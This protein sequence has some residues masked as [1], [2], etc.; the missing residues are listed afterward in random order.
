VKVRERFTAASASRQNGALV[1]D[2]LEAAGVRSISY[3][4]RHGF[5]AVVA[6]PEW[7]ADEARQ[8]LGKV[9]S[10]AGRL[11]TADASTGI[12]PLLAEWRSDGVRRLRLHERVSDPSRTLLLGAEVACELQLWTDHGP[13]V[14]APVQ[15]PWGRW[16][17]ADVFDSTRAAWPPPAPADQID[18]P[19]D[20]VYTW[21]D[22]RDPDWSARRDQALRET[23][24]GPA[25]ATSLGEAR[26]RS[27][28][29]LRYS[30]RSLDLFAPFV[31]H[32]YL[33]TADQ[34]PEWLDTRSPR[35]TVVSHRELFADVHHL[36]TFNSHAIEAHLHRI[37]G[38]AE[39]YLYVN[40]DFFFGRPVRPELFFHPN[41][42]S[43]FFLS[44]ATIPPG[45]P[46]DDD[47]GVDAAAKNGQR[48][49]TER[50]GRRVAHK[51]K[52]VPQP[53][54]RSWLENLEEQFSP[55]LRATA[56]HRFRHPGDYSVPSSLA[57]HYSYLQG[58]ATPGSIRYDYITLSDLDRAEHRFA[59]LLKGRD[60]DTI[61]INDSDLLPVDELRADA[62]IAGFLQRYF[63][64]PSEFEQ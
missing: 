42:V 17:P 14:E 55:E 3:L 27:R 9:R 36:P 41:G 34:Q 16:F 2:A 59:D 52:H 6:V 63:P 60:R 58:G 43:K 53:Q 38:L 12:A 47:V 48:L 21:V 50:F 7:Q 30:L 1:R 49:L 45:P 13:L 18:F 11:P 44:R 40:D 15:T 20:V 29:E 5:R 33:V 56:S 46:S 37:E 8:A 57:H 26:F 64:V 28:D 24:R 35:L 54:R 32:V 22:D 31:R 61:C 39:H 19:I 51:F 4:P 62:L 25:H 23:G 10:L